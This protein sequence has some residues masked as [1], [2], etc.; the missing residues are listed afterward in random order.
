MRAKRWIVAAAVIL[1][2][3]LA[4]LA[5]AQGPCGDDPLNP[6]GAIPWRIPAYP[7][8]YSPTPYTPQPTPT[9]MEAT[10]TPSSTNTPTVTPTPSPTIA[11]HGDDHDTFGTL[12]ADQVAVQETLAAMQDQQINN[13][14]AATA[15]ALVGEYAGTFAGYMRGL[16]LFNIKGTGGVLGFLLLAIA[17]ALLVMII[18]NII[19]II[20]VFARWV[21]RVA[22]LVAEF[23]PF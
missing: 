10:Y 9:P 15:A 23:I 20:A 22:Q 1:L 6:C 4:G 17:F 5:G 8:L 11:Y 2:A 18:T 16:Q 12:A 14:G 3:G 7:I 13:M 19:P 21:M